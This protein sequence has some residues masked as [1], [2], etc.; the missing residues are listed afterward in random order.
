[1]DVKHKCHM[2]NKPH[3]NTFSE[4]ACWVN[5]ML[6]TENIMLQTTHS[7]SIIEFLLVIS[8]I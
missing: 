7:V 5:V 2:M 1:M 3:F 6:S 8:L 4:D